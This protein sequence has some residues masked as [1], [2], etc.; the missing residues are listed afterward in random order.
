MIPKESVR[1]EDDGTYTLNDFTTSERYIVQYLSQNAKGLL[2]WRITIPLDN[3]NAVHAWDIIHSIEELGDIVA[4][5]HTLRPPLLTKTYMNWSYV[6]LDKSLTHIHAK[7]SIFPNAMYDFIN[8]QL[9]SELLCM[10]LTCIVLVALLT[11]EIG[12]VISRFLLSL[13]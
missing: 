9:N 1:R 11:S 5:D 3:L 10:E 4:G 2:M 8:K 7:A 6:P 12:A 13:E